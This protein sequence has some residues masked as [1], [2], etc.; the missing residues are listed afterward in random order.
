MKKAFLAMLALPSVFVLCL[1][2]ALIPLKQKATSFTR[3]P[4]VG[5]PPKTAFYL[6]RPYRF[7]R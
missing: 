7:L 2:C 4:I 1:S 6:A 5:T 3:S